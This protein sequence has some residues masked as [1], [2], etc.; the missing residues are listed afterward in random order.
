[1]IRFFSNN[2][3]K[4]KITLNYLNNSLT[5]CNNSNI[6]KFLQ[7]NNNNN[8]N[9][10]K[11]KFYSTTTTQTTTTTTKNNLNTPPS[12]ISNSNIDYF[13]KN[14]TIEDIKNEQIINS[15]FNSSSR[16]QASI[17]KLIEKEPNNP[18]H[19]HELIEINRN[20]NSNQ[21]YKMLQVDNTGDF[22]FHRKVFKINGV[23]IN[24]IDLHLKII[25][26][27]DT[28]KNAHYNLYLLYESLKKYNNNKNINNNIN[29]NNSNNNNNNNNSNNN[30]NKDRLLSSIINKFVLKNHLDINNNNNNNN[31]IDINNDIIKLLNG[32]EMKPIDLLI[33]EFYNNDQNFEALLKIAN[34][35]KDFVHDKISLPISKDQWKE[36]SKLA[37]LQKV[38][39]LKKGHPVAISQIIYF[40]KTTKQMKEFRLLDGQSL[41]IKQLA[42]MAYLENRGGLDPNY[43]ID[44]TWLDMIDCLD[45]GNFSLKNKKECRVITLTSLV[46]EAIKKFPRNTQFHYHLSKSLNNNLE[47]VDF[48]FNNENENENNPNSNNPNNNNNNNNSNKDD[49]NSNKLETRYLNRLDF[50]KIAILDQL[51]KINEGDSNQLKLLSDYYYSASTFLENKDQTIKIKGIQLNNVDLLIRALEIDM[52][53]EFTLNSKLIVKELIQLLNHDEIVKVNG[54]SMTRESLLLLLLGPNTPKD[55]DSFYNIS[56]FTFKKLIEHYENEIKIINSNNSNN[57]NNNNNNKIISLNNKINRYRELLKKSKEFLKNSIIEKLKKDPTNSDNYFNLSQILNHDET[58]IIN[59]NDNNNNN[60]DINKQW[61][62]IDLILK[63]IDLE[64][65]KKLTYYSLFE[66]L[67]LPTSIKN[68]KPTIKLIDGTVLEKHQLLYLELTNY[69]RNTNAYYQFGL[70]LKEINFKELATKL[71]NQCITFDPK[72]SNA[73][74]ELGMILYD[75]KI[76]S[77]AIKHQTGDI[78]MKYSRKQ[79]FIKALE[80][81]NPNGTLN[82]KNSLVWYHLSLEMNDGNDGG[83]VVDIEF[84]KTKTDILSLIIENDPTF[85]KSYY[86][87]SNLLKSNQDKCKVTGLNRLELLSKSIQVESNI[88][89]LSIYFS[90]LSNYLQDHE[91][92]ILKDGRSMNKQQLLIEAIETNPRGKISSLYYDLS[93][94]LSDNEDDELLLFNKPYN[95]SQLVKE[96]IDCLNKE[97]DP[98]Y[99]NSIRLKSNYY[100]NLIKSLLK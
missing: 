51:E 50:I 6:H 53:F 95:K 12:L 86:E 69:P 100:L 56:K 32:K 91:K 98:D 63:S 96:A 74:L 68:E 75:L 71:F 61:N 64:P 14:F 72:F 60:V 41:T 10:I 94:T 44:Q 35:L 79:L 17:I 22:L 84:N 67:S 52:K 87:L 40:M 31:N 78:I 19:Y 89:Q 2:L 11:L 92:I 15:A 16:K 20:Q 55:N 4:S 85:S 21:L 80:S 62:K 57:S 26:L 97:N 28:F 58:I 73:Y 8:N 81:E 13:N 1:M 65:T 93:K 7:K 29:D 45:Q 99:I 49:K 76:P 47:T 30:N 77:T 48:T 23:D 38:L 33:K 3:N 43:I 54:K 27:D 59:N 88:E 5:K 36:V 39:D 82:L 42:L 34:H 25:D 9:N 90:Q 37:I 18:N 24:M 83:S 66:Y 46:L 70:H